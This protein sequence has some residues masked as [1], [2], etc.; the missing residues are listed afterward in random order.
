MK[1]EIFQMER[2]QSTWENL[3]D[4]DLSESGVYPVSI[5]EL[6]EMGFD[7]E[8]AL[9]TPLSYS[10]GNGTPELREALGVIYP[11]AS[12]DQIEVTNGTSEANFMIALSLLREGDEFALEVPNYMQLWGVPRSF[13]AQVNKFRLRAD[14]DWEPDWEEFEAAVNPRTRLVY[15]S[16]PNNPTGSTLSPQAMERIVRRVEEVDA[17]L[18]ADEV[19]LGAEIHRERTP[20]FWGM[21][22]RV[23]VTSGL[24]KAYGIPGVRIGWIVGPESV[25][26]DC[27]TQ[28]DSITICPNKLSDAI[29]RVAVDPENR[30]K[31]YSRGRELLQGNLEIMQGWIGAL[32]DGFEFI[33]PEAGAI[34]FVRY[35]GDI[36]SIDLSERIRRRQN[37]LIVPGTHLGMEG[38]VRIWMGGQPDYLRAGLERVESELK[39]ALSRPA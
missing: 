39:A 36:A 13:G 6:M 29:A 23:I 35:P 24:S 3:V 25:V 30:S 38:Y 17:Y 1:I 15:L 27:W 7:L 31:L 16:N 10:Q 8:W 28:H 20:S 12:I 32:G 37:T 34:C 11:G 5:R 19:Y 9:D 33:P 2:M 4:Y 18:I 26:T 22:D 14:C 21:S